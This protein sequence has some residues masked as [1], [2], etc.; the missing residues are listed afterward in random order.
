MHMTP[1]IRVNLYRLPE[2]DIVSPATGY[3]L[4]AYTQDINL[5]E[6]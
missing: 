2:D 6:H 1:S 3:K 5:W 4:T